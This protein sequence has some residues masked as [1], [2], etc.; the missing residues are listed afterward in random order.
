MR[1]VIFLILMQ[2]ISRT[3]AYAAVGFATGFILAMFALAFAGALPTGPADNLSQT[4]LE[5]RTLSM[6]VAIAV[7]VAASGFAILAG[8][9][10]VS[11][12]WARFAIVFGV[13]AVL[14]VWPS[15]S[16]S[17]LPLATPYVNF[18]FDIKI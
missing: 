10:K 13:I 5:Q 11:I 3:I 12:Y 14:P 8:A 4:E 16:G 17:L 6:R 7:G 1:V 15:K 9:K 18:G 2:M